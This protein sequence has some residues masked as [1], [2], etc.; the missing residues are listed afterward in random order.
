MFSARSNLTQRAGAAANGLAYGVSGKS[1]HVVT[2]RLV[3]DA[4]QSVSGTPVAGRAMIEVPTDVSFAN[5]GPVP[6][7]DGA[8][9]ALLAQALA[10]ARTVAP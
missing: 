6:P 5:V 8:A 3:L 2:F 10:A 1:H 4:P 9:P 7:A